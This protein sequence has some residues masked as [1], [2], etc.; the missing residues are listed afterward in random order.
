MDAAV[1]IQETDTSRPLR[2]HLLV[3]VDERH[4]NEG[5]LRWAAAEAARLKL[6]LRL[7]TICR[8]HPEAGVYVG[9]GVE[10]STRAGL[11]DLADRL[12]ADVEVLPVSVSSGG[13]VT[14]LLSRAAG[15]DLLVVG[16]RDLG[17]LHR[18]T[19]GSTSIAV[20]GR[21]PV[22]VVVV[23][24]GWASEDGAPPPLV[25]GVRLPES[26]GETD[27]PASL[28]YAFDRARTLQVPLVVVHA[29]EV[30]AVLSW[31]PLDLAA[32]RQRV[33]GRVERLLLP[34]RR[35]HPGVEVDV[36]V[37]ADRPADALRE[38]AATSQ[39]VILGRRTAPDRHGGFRLGS[40]ARAFLHHA[41]TP[42]AVVPAE[43]AH[44]S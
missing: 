27:H 10:D 22:T 20:A 33:T 11:Q 12:A 37:M 7:A 16:H 14:G 34:W 44:P 32:E 29:W 8:I 19:L 23:P 18:S 5:A 2:P 40:T 28:D 42:V 31:S 26:E 38:A 9:S 21:S 4:V 17:T 24:D 6:A 41:E 43:R 13:P 3:G 35:R 30:P 15:A 1:D 39:L 25:L 36:R